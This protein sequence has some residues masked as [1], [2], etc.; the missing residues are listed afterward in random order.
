MRSAHMVRQAPGANW[1]IRDCLRSRMFDDGIDAVRVE[2]QMILDGYCARKP[3]STTMD[4][5][6]I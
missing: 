2:R 4:W 5:P 6:V 3:P 1:A